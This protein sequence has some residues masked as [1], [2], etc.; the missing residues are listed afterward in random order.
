MLSGWTEE[1]ARAELEK[2]LDRSIP[3]AHWQYLVANYYVDDF[4][5]MDAADRPRL[6][7]SSYRKLKSDGDLVMERASGDRRSMYPGPPLLITPE[8]MALTAGLGEAMARRAESDSEI[9][10][11]HARLRTGEVHVTADDARQLWS[12]RLGEDDI[13]IRQYITEVARR[14]GWH[15]EDAAIYVLSGWV[16][17]VDPIT[18]SVTVTEFP[19]EYGA[20]ESRSRARITLEFDP[21]VSLETVT[22]AYRS[23]RRHL[24]GADRK[25]PKPKDIEAFRFVVR[26]LD[27]N[28]RPDPSWSEIGRR[29]NAKHKDDGWAYAR[30]EDIRRPY[31]SIRDRFINYPFPDVFPG[32]AQTAVPVK[33]RE[34]GERRRIVVDPQEREPN[35]TVQVGASSEVLK[36]RSPNL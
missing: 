5:H 35:D 11:H 20:P 23:I 31:E 12:D 25:S 19:D 21:W 10:A 24:L 17:P 14:Y 8:E 3:D 22:E 28:G 36:R 4:A 18:A 30:P 26:H 13:R 7:A 33:G 15:L 1:V 29:W 2:E 34:R 9:A 16:A 6:L 32:D 27:D